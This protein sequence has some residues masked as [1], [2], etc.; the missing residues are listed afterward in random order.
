MLPTVVA[1][2][3]LVG[4]VGAMRRVVPPRRQPP[5]LV[6]KKHRVSRSLERQPALL[7]PDLQAFPE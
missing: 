5:V 6:L 2:G 3:V 1:R 4:S 7:F